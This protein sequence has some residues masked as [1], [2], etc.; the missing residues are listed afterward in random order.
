MQIS[1]LTLLKV[2]SNMII[3]STFKNLKALR[4]KPTF[5]RISSKPSLFATILLKSIGSIISG[6][7]S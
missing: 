6:K 4:T 1:G 2:P 7:K 3:D 5:P